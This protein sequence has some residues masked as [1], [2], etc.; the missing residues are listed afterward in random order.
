MDIIRA[1]GDGDDFAVSFQFL[2]SSKKMETAREECYSSVKLSKYYFQQCEETF[3][4][5]CKTMETITGNCT[6]I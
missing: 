5:H 3:D 4:L 2:T 1:A 6:L